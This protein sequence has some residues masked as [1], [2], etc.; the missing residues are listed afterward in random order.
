[1]KPVIV[2]GNLLKAAPNVHDLANDRAP[3]K[4]DARCLRKQIRISAPARLKLDF[5]T[6]YSLPSDEV[7]I[8]QKH[9]SIRVASL[10]AS[11]PDQHVAQMRN[12][13][14]THFEKRHE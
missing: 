6:E 12:S 2:F 10:R 11:S 8:F 14:V 4:G 9:A 7:L 13:R 5:Q 1:M 3:S